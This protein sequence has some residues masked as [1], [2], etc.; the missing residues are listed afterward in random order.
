MEFSTEART[1]GIRRKTMK[2]S[3]HSRSVVHDQGQTH[4]EILVEMIQEVERNE[5]KRV[6]V[7]QVVLMTVMTV[8]IGQMIMARRRRRKRCWA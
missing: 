4:T 2:T 8:G 5:V 1:Q 3:I 7:V 6:P